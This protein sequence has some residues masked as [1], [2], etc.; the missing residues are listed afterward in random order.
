MIELTK[1]NGELIV[2]NVDQIECI[3]VIPESKIT[4]INGRHH[5]VTESTDTIIEKVIE[6]RKCVR[7]LEIR[8][9]KSIKEDE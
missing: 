2:L 3:E 8:V 4:L 1:I 9:S 7:G 5:I 6:Y